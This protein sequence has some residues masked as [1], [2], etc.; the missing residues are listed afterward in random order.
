MWETPTVDSGTPPE[1]LFLDVSTASDAVPADAPTFR[2]ALPA[3]RQLARSAADTSESSSRAEIR[4][5]SRPR[6]AMLARSHKGIRSSARAIVGEYAL[7][8]A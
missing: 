1:R 8:D 5:I 4:L 7:Q 3:S 6:R 2:T